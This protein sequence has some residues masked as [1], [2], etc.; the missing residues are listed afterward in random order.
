MPLF[1]LATG[2]SAA[3]Q[4]GNHDEVVKVLASK[5]KESRHIM[6]IVNSRVV[7]EIFTSPQGTWTMLV[8]N[9][10]GTSC[11]T[12]AGENWQESPATVAGLES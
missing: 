7:M 12:A 1:T 9:T 11:I 10:T 8:T 2:A 5:F 4:C 3:T 6:G